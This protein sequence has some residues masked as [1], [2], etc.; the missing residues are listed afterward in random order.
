MARGGRG[1]QSIFMGSRRGSVFRWIG[2]RRRE[3][4]EAATRRLES[5]RSFSDGQGTA[6]MASPCSRNSLKRT[7]IQLSF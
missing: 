7:L 3:I 4:K 2:R 1:R 6:E 5:V